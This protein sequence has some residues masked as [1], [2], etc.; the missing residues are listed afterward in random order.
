MIY[1]M[2]AFARV[3][4]QSDLGQLVCE[5]RSI[6]HRY[7]EI[8]LHLP[9]MLRQF[10]MPIRERIRKLIKRGK[11]EC[12]VRYQI[13]AKS[14][15]TLFT[16]NKVLVQELCLA[17]EEIANLLVTPAA[18]HPTDILRFPGVLETQ[19]TDVSQ[20]QDDIFKLIEHA[21]Q[22]LSEAR[23]REG[24]ELKQLFIQRLDLM[25]A[26][27]EKIKERLP[28]VILDQ[29]E[30]L[31][32]RFAEVRLELDPL[33][34]EQEMVVFCQRIDVAEEI[35]RTETHINEIK[36]VL[37]QGG[38][39]GRRL[40]FLLQ[41]LNREANTIGSKSVDSIIT[42]AAVEIK[43]LIEQIREQIQNVE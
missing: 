13:S 20:W 36:R 39:L 19:D 1:S 2:T 11:I 16:L 33:R 14:T 17:S 26:A 40:D 8:A 29:N 41:E 27:L 32:K 34:L 31:K 4:Q 9:E 37:N 43:V 23:G 25:Q 38:A 6:N 3:Q 35:E 10:E 15:G 7:L 5:M 28:Q 24:K 30:R 22:E 42:H 21:V 18:V 12:T